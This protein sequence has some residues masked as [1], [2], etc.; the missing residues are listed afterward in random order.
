MKPIGDLALFYSLRR[1]RK[2]AQAIFAGVWGVPNKQSERTFGARS[3]ERNVQKDIPF[4][5][6]PMLS[7]IRDNSDVM[8]TF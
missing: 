8:G 5:C 6:L 2:K 7:R 4:H 1:V 3:M